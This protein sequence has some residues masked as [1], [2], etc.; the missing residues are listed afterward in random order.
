MSDTDATLAHIAA[1]GSP[2][3]AVRRS[4]AFRTRA[5]GSSRALRTQTVFSSE[6]KKQS[7]SVV[8][9]KSHALA[10]G[11]HSTD[12]RQGSANR[13]QRCVLELHRCPT[14]AE[15]TRQSASA[16]QRSAYVRPSPFEPATPPV[17]APLIPSP[18]M[19][20]APA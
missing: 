15:K 18:A 2:S 8:H 17:L 20:P 5:R 12:E 9:A 7:A 10:S 1:N 4:N 19:P 14:S 3:P 16:L 6:K 11:M 13:S